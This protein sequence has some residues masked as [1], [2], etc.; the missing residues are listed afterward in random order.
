[1]NCR[2]LK[3]KRFLHPDGYLF[4]K[5][6]SHTHPHPHP[7]SH[8][9]THPKSLKRKKLRSPSLP[10]SPSSV[11]GASRRC[12]IMPS[13]PL[14]HKEKKRRRKTI[15]PPLL[16]VSPSSVCSQLRFASFN[17]FVRRFR[18]GLDL[19]TPPLCVC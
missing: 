17:R 14:L 3:K 18:V 10:P 5:Y 2:R 4:F 8:T 7:H 6:T 9:H 13:A 15:R 1:M 16:H 11:G 12:I 19:G